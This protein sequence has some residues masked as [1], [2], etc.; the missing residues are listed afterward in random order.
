MAD[1][2]PHSTWLHR[3][4]VGLMVAA[5]L[6]VLGFMTAVAVSLWIA[7]TYHW[8]NTSFRKRHDDQF[9]EQHVRQFVDPERD[10]IIA[11]HAGAVYRV[12]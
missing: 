6:L 2:T 4:V 11:V 3:V 8:E 5:A 7:N 1:H 10:L 12:G 9:R